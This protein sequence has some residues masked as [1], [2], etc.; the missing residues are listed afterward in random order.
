VRASAINGS[1]PWAK[2]QVVGFVAEGT[3]CTEDGVATV[4]QTREAFEHIGTVI[5]QMSGRVGDI[6]TAVGQIAD[7]S[8]RAEQDINA[9]ALV[10]EQSS[11]SVEE[12]S[13]S[14]EQTSASA[15]E[16]AASAQSLSSTAQEL[17][18]LVSRF[19]VV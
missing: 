11:A 18:A 16:I 12:V 17:N 5:D 7:G 19:K 4:Q 1:V 8:G 6:V 13:A 10:A 9:V 2:T 3:R 14:T 15:Q